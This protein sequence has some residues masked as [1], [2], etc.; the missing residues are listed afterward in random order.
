[1]VKSKGYDIDERYPRPISL[2]DVPQAFPKINL[3]EGFRIKSLADENNLQKIHRVLWRGFNHA[4]EPPEN[5]IEDRRKMRSGPNFR[6][7]LTIVIEDP[8]G[9]FVSFCGMWFEAVN[10]I[11]YVEPV[12]TDPDFRRVG[13]GKAAVWEGI[14][15]CAFLG[16]TAVFVG[17]DLEFYRRI[18]FTKR[19]DS[20]CWVRQF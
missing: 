4:G 5:G 9:N 3:P 8:T 19:F 16:A 13:L 2:L 14:R 10:K 6:K 7:D 15:R 12:A 20:N 11:A 1:M 17:S 18:G